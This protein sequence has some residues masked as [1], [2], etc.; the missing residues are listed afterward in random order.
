MS[1]SLTILGSSSAIPTTK[2][3]PTAQLLNVDER[4]FL[5][6]CGE[7]TQIQLS[8]F[9]I[10]LAKINDIF[11]SHLHGDHIFGLFGLISTFSLM[12]RENDLN[13]YAEQ[14]LED[15]LKSHLSYFGEDLPFHIRF[16]P[17]TSSKSKVIYE[18]EKL[19]VT[20]IP[21]KHRVPVCGFLFREKARPM[22]ILK[23][24]IARYEI[25]VK[26]IPP[27][28]AGADFVS[29][30]GTLIPNEK[31]T[32]AP[33]KSRSYAFLTDTRMLEKNVPLLKDVDLLYHEATFLHK[34]AELAH[35]TYHSTAVEAA[36]LAQ[37]CN[38][39]RLLL[40]HFSI[41]YKS[42]SPFLE[43][44]RKIFEESYVVEDGDTFRI[45]QTRLKR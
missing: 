27:I 29:A 8:R 33:F 44:A 24:V 20:S 5:I 43:E 45:E 9:K 34:D 41:R 31:L 12:G 1:F 17:V 23:V 35:D 14:R 16:H 42:T 39:G 3:F 37:K 4:F 19:T 18:D 15:I 13:I 26:Q 10:R 32:M 40:G 11:I 28:K 25:P 2:R 38:A 7:G 22:N 6:D 36:Q 21:L 30:D